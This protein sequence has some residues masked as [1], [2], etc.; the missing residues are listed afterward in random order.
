LVDKYRRHV[1]EAAKI[2]D[3]APVPVSSW[4]VSTTPTTNL[5][6]FYPVPNAPQYR[7]LP[8]LIPP[9]NIFTRRSGPA[10]GYDSDD[11]RRKKEQRKGKKITE[12]NPERCHILLFVWVCF[13]RFW[14]SKLDS[15]FITGGFAAPEDVAKFHLSTR[16]WQD[17][18]HGDSFRGSKVFDIQQFWTYGDVFGCAGYF[19]DSSPVP[20][21][22]G[23]P[24]TPDDFRCDTLKSIVVWD[25]A[26]TSAK[27][28][29]LEA[30]D[31]L[32]RNSGLSQASLHG[33]CA[34][35]VRLFKDTC[36]I[37]RDPHP[38]Q[39]DCLQ[40]R[41]SWIHTFCSL[42]SDW[43]QYT[44]LNNPPHKADIDWVVS[45]NTQ[46]L[47]AFLNRYIR[48]YYQGI[49]DALRTSPTPLLIRPD[50]SLLSPDYLTM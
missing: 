33:R 5:R 28:Q 32:M 8:F 6:P 44:M 19:E 20:L 45:L 2:A 38:S 25:A 10:Q 34:L 49:F 42:I 13:R 17:L 39:S 15:L 29:F 1:E 21:L 16:K 43:P 23:R 24:L 7:F 36:D 35:R 41:Q 9:P 11:E 40:T 27:Y 4:E 37:S 50:T 47:D 46:D 48:I 18:L 26:L 3:W 31:M 14:Q 12:R 30:D 22:D